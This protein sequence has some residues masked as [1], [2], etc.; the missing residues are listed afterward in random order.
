MRKLQ[1]KI[2]TV[3]RKGFGFITNDDGSGDL[4]CHFSSLVMDGFRTLN[5]GDHV[6]FETTQ[7][8]K[9]LQASSV[10]IIQ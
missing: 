2:K 8:P 1:G 3:N 7:G 5:E 6:E 10:K 4:F 9:G